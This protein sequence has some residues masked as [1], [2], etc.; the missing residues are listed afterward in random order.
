MMDERFYPFLKW[1]AIIL[2]IAWIGW[3]FFDSF[4]AQVA[5]GDSAYLAGN[6]LFEDGHYERALQAYQEALHEAPEHIHALR[7]KARSLLKLERYQEAL[8]VFNNV[9][10]KE[11][12]FAGSYANR[13]ILYDWMGQHKEALA[14]YE[15][16]LKKDGELGDGPNWFTR[17]FR[18]QP[19]KPPTIVERARY[20]RE[21][22]AKPESE[23]LLRLPEDDDK[24]RP[25]K[26]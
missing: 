8:L 21:Q 16:A 26:M 18:L 7:G 9:I 6:N 15:H 13:G 11:P 5:P 17:F 1:T 2:T 19:E 20:L 10:A 23:R 4:F 22:L 24:Q 12:H 14:D 3:T 25:Y